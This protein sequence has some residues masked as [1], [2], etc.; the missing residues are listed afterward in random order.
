MATD[1]TIP[2]TNVSAP[3][4]PY[5]TLDVFP[6]HDAKY[7]KGGFRSVQT[8]ADRDDITDDR[9]EAGMFV[10]VVENEK[11]YVLENN[12]DNW[13]WV[14]WESGGGGGGGESYTYYGTES[15]VWE[16]THNKEKYPNSVIVIDSTDNQ[17]IIGDVVYNNTNKITIT[18]SESVT[19]TAYLNF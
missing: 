3:I 15:S 12:N 19:G 17:T 11:I 6:T 14:E 7:G 4:A 1:T 10:Y 2:G 8:I 13:I 9:K 16:I 5:S 18:F